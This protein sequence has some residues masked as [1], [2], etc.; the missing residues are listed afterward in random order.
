M[1][2]TDQHSADSSW[3]VKDPQGYEDIDW[4]L[5][6]E[7]WLEPPTEDSELLEAVGFEEGSG[8]PLQPGLRSSSLRQ[9][10]DAWED[11]DRHLEEEL[12]EGPFGLPPPPLVDGWALWH[13]V[14]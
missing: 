11:L 5:G 6:E 8:P 2:M 4:L 9:E 12:E 7:A 3:A 13:G 14:L 1:P 10:G